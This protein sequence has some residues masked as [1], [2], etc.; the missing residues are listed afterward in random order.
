LN[1]LRLEAR[2][3]KFIYFSYQ[4]FL[5]F[6]SKRR[7]SILFS[8][9]NERE[10][11]IKKSF[12]LL[13]HTVSFDKF[14]YENV[15]KHDLLIPLSLDDIRLLYSYPELAKR[16]P[17]PIPS[18]KSLDICDDKYLF[19]TTLVDKGFESYLPRVG[20][21][22]RMPYIVKKKIAHMG[23]NCYVIDTPEKQEQ[24]KS[25]IHDP[26]YFCQEI[27]QGE[28]EYATHF[29][30]INGKVVRALNMIYIFPTPTYV[31]GRDKFI[32]NRLWSCPHTKLFTEILDS[33]GY[34]GLC[35]FNYKEIDGKPYVFEI[36][37][38]FGSSLAM[39]FFS[40]LKNLK[41]PPASAHSYQEKI[42]DPQL[43]QTS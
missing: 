15:K 7:L 16:N 37:P 31:K 2:A 18:I 8:E 27:V 38:R 34:E 33:I 35:C 12:R 5:A 11:D 40:F 14:T 29:L 28:K 26:D 25:E 17:I 13:R 21:N 36:N 43:K 9:N 10:Q 1:T 4:T 3:N 32:C 22:L 41:F 42:I 30:Y 6:F 20:E 39:F 23:M 19:Y 24:Y